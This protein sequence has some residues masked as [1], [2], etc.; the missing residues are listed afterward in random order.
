MIHHRQS[1]SLC[2]EASQNILGGHSRA[3]DLQSYLAADGLGLLG[4]VDLSH[5]T[6]PDLLPERVRTDP[7]ANDR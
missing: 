4:D 5:A 7:S 6:F 3:D 2:L 1:L